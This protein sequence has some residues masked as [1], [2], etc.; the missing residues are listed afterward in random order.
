MR[1]SFQRATVSPPA[2]T[3][4]TGLQRSARLLTPG[5]LQDR[6]LVTLWVLSSFTVFFPPLLLEILR[7][8]SVLRL[9]GVTLRAI[10]CDALGARELGRRE[11]STGGDGT[12]LIREA[13]SQHL[14]SGRAIVRNAEGRLA[15]RVHSAFSPWAARLRLARNSRSSARGVSPASRYASPA[16][17]KVSAMSR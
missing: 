17:R 16:R 5:L 7:Q 1:F 8:E 14:V 9:W 10:I 3:F 4:A 11:S 13:R 12:V 2:G 6:L 15:A